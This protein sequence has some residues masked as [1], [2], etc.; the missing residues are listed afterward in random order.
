LQSLKEEPFNG[1]SPYSNLPFTF[2]FSTLKS[3]MFGSL[4]SPILAFPMIAH[5]LDALHRHDEEV[6]LSL[7]SV[8]YPSY[9]PFCNTK[10]FTRVSQDAQL[11]VMC[12]DKRYP[13]NETLPELRK[14]FDS[15]ANTS[16]Y[17]DVWMSLMIG[18]DAY[19]IT[20]TDPPMRWDDHPSHRQTPINTSYPLMFLSNTADP[21]TPLFAG[22]KMARKFVGAGLLELQSEGHCSLAAA[23]RC[24][25]KKV[26]RYF[27]EGVVPARPERG[28]KGQEIEGGVWDRC[29]ADEEPWMPFDSDAWI[30]RV[31]RDQRWNEIE[32][33]EN[34]EELLALE[35]LME[36]AWD[37]MRLMDGWKDVQQL[38]KKYIRPMGLGDA[39]RADLW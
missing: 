13:L 11:A 21:V 23:S 32:E 6:I 29:E 27:E 14:R 38:A 31:K 1:I 25:L 15:I 8:F 33:I 16:R 7:I 10:R 37:T 30:E 22:V 26:R 35:A 5:I 2:T 39:P 20:P 34:E 12:S 19:D 9:K 17:A 18:C 28:P 24:T 36:D 3:F 4:Y